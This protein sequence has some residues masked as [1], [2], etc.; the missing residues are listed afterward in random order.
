MT[1]INNITFKTAFYIQ[2][3]FHYASII[4][5]YTYFSHDR[6]IHIWL[7]VLDLIFHLR[8]KSALNYARNKWK[9][10]KYNKR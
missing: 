2:Q 5:V 9:K 7:L 1:S 8:A 4:F 10:L 3:K 6:N